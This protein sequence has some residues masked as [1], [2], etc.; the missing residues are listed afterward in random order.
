VLAIK[1]IV[2]YFIIYY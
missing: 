2:Y 1:L